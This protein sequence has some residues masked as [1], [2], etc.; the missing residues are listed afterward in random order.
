MLLSV[1]EDLM[2]VKTF[3]P[4]YFVKRLAQIRFQTANPSAPW[5]T[6]TAITALQDLLK[7][8][9][10][11]YEFGSG[12]STV[13][14]ARRVRTLYSMEH[15]PEWYER[16]RYKLEQ[17]KLL[18][19][20]DYQLAQDSKHIGNDDPFDDNHPY[21][22]NLAEMPENSLDFILVDGIM[23]LTCIRISIRKLKPGGFL[24]L[25]NANRYIPNNYPEG[26]TTVLDHR[27]IPRD[28]EWAK[29][30]SELSSWRGFNT[31]DSIN[32]TRFWIKFC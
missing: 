10:I 6:A 13:W 29:T 27:S 19:K 15:N 3:Y 21:V 24:V 12:R 22:K 7:P 1:S 20:V 11:G 31:T 26:Y 4:P 5:L 16:V 25:D 9:D 23:R 2:N 17:A 14:L 28:Q 8:D 30:L 18:E 32:D